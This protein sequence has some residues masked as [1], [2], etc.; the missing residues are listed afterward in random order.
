MMQQNISKE[1][2]IQVADT[3]NLAG[4]VPA[5][6]DEDSTPPEVPDKVQVKDPIQ[7]VIETTLV[8]VKPDNPEP[9]Q[10]VKSHLGNSLDSDEKI[11]QPHCST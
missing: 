10:A 9:D 2:T 3:E 4:P 6:K 8:E 11:Q 7:L 1:P 5:L